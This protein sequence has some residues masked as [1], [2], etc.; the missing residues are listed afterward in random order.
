MSPATQSLTVNRAGVPAGVIAIPVRTRLV[1]TG[2]D[3][4]ALVCEA[5]RGIAGPGDVIT[6]SET[7]LAGSVTHFPFR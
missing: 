6:V 4:T 5:V 1:Q 7:A 3:L 2:D